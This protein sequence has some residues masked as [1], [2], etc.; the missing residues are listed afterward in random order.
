M[1]WPASKALFGVHS[2]SGRVFAVFKDE[3]GVWEA[4][5]E[6]GNAGDAVFERGDVDGLLRDDSR[7]PFGKHFNASP[8]W[9]RCPLISASR[10]LCYFVLEMRRSHVYLIRADIC[11]PLVCIGQNFDAESCIA[12]GFRLCS[13]HAIL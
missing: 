11:C 3:R 4:A 8:G 6:G 7:S 5:L 12:H 9:A 10:T 2:A 13:L 1:P